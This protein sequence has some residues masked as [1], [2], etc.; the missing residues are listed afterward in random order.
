MNGSRCVVARADGS[1]QARR[2]PYRI[3]GQNSFL[4][5]H[6]NIIGP[7]QGKR[8]F[9]H[10]FGNA[11]RT[12]LTVCKP[13]ALLPDVDDVLMYPLP[14]PVREFALL[15]AQQAVA[16]RIHGQSS[17]YLAIEKR[18]TT[19][20]GFA[21]EYKYLPC[22]AG[23]CIPEVFQN[24]CQ[25]DRLGDSRRNVAWH[26]ADAAGGSH[27]LHAACAQDSAGGQYGGG[28]GGQCGAGACG[29]V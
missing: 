26:A 13:A 25:I 28:S 21:P 4:Q 6:G 8:L 12:G 7:G 22:A 14:E 15:P 1:I 11:S 29:A 24:K 18:N 16:D 10:A 5:I 3:D 23:G 20:T 2:W 17:K 9:E 27:R 19:D